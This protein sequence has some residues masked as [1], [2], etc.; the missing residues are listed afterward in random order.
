[1]IADLPRAASASSQQRSD[2]VVDFHRPVRMT[3]AS[4][5]LSTK[6]FAGSP[7]HLAPRL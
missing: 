7:I 5:I 1:M 2:I 3:D 4:S 6:S